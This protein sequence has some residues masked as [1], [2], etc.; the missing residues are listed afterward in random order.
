MN[1]APM[2]AVRP[3]KDK[4]YTVD[5]RKPRANAELSVFSVANGFQEIVSSKPTRKAPVFRYFHYTPNPKVGIPKA[6]LEAAFK[7][8]AAAAAPPPVAAPPAMPQLPVAPANSQ[9][10]YGNM[11]NSEGVDEL[12][13]FLAEQGV[14]S[15]GEFDELAELMEQKASIM[16]GGR[17][18]NKKTRRHRKQRKSRKASRRN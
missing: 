15:Q 6:D 8:A 17:R 14:G 2:R 18:R 11:H 4:V 12:A 13:M 10:S 9:G 16:G 5:T 7:A 3:S 1:N